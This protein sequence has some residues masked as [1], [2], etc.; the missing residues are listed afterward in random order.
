[1]KRCY[2]CGKKKRS[3]LVCRGKQDGRL[4]KSCDECA[5]LERASSRKRLQ[6]V[7][8]PPEPDPTPPTTETFSIACRGCGMQL[9]A[10]PWHTLCECCRATRVANI[11]AARPAGIPVSMP[12]FLPETSGDGATP[13]PV[14]FE[15]NAA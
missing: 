15:E 12:V 10:R 7:P 9:N 13:S 14:L 5:A 6:A 2:R 4:Y 1:M 3:I 11:I 8:V